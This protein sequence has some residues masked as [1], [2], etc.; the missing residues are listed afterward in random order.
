MTSTETGEGC[1]ACGLISGDIPLP[2]GRIYESGG[3]VVEHCV[4][5]LGLG[6]VIVKPVR[7]VVRV[8]D[9]DAVQA[10]ALGPL[11]QRAAAAVE[12]VIECDQVYVCLW[13]H[14]GANPV[15]IHFVVQP[16]TKTDMERFGTHGPD[17]QVA[18][19]RDGTC[20]NHASIDAVSDRLRQE[21][22]RT[23]PA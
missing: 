20:P 10:A 7:H 15:H 21:L 22:V 12:S 5:P 1:F 13:S 17:L 2:G 16:V 9:L 23:D 19:F 4:G 3:W 8:A 14:A 6:T 18:M 11:L